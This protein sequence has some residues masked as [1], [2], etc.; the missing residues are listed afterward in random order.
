MRFPE[1]NRYNM[2][3]ICL[4]TCYR[5]PTYIR[6]KTIEAGLKYNKVKNIIVVKNSKRGLLRYFEVVLKLIKARILHNPD[7]YFVTFR[8][9]E[10]LPFVLLIG[11]GKKIVFDEFINPIEWVVYEHRKIPKGSVGERVLINIYKSMLKR[12]DTIVTDTVSHAMYSANLMKL[13]LSKYQTV[14]VGT[15]EE[16]FKSLRSNKK[17]GKFQVLYYGSMLPLHGIE[18]VIQA[19]IDM[20]DDE[21]IEFLLIGGGDGLKTDIDTA[22]SKGANIKYKKWV[23]YEKLPRVIANSD[24][25]LGGPFGDTIQSRFVITGKAIQFL[26]MGKPVIV[27]KNEESV[28][29]KDKIDAMIID[30]GSAEAIKNA[31]KWLYENPD[32]MKSMSNH[33]VVL[34]EKLFSSIVLKK[35]MAKL[36]NLY[37]L[38]NG[39]L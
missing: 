12:V 19:A 17:D 23:S 39:K 4:V 21:M 18:H 16:N 24:V 13:P 22:I 2:P 35:D 34:Y 7:L 29:F 33:G 38:K 10:I 9:Y 27:G 25:C 14:T 15:D 11:L 30:Q 20:K 5:N 1:N 31:I 3:S 8:G 32:K 36:L 6:V 37:K 28:I 26:R